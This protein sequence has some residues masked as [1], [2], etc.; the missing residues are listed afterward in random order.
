LY[1]SSQSDSLS[2]FEDG[3]S[4]QYSE[5]SIKPGDLVRIT[6]KLQGL[7]LQMVEDN[8]WTGKSRIQHNILQ[9]YKIKEEAA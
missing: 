6:V 2:F 1:L 9:I 8:I 5:T 3:K 4:T 7:S